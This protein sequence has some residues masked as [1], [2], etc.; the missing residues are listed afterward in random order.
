MITAS[1]LYLLGSLVT[2]FAPSLQILILGR[3]L[4]GTGIGLVRLCIFSLR[5]TVR[6]HSSSCTYI[7]QHVMSMENEWFPEFFLQP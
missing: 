3:L 2:G 6:K 4:Y 7:V 5:G 1:V